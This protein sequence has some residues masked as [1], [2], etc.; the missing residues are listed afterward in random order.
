MPLV[1]LAPVPSAEESFKA[2]V[3]YGFPRPYPLG[4]NGI[5][6]LRGDGVNVMPTKL[7]RQSFDD[8]TKSRLRLPRTGLLKNLLWKFQPAELPAASPPPVYDSNQGMF[9]LGCGGDCGCKEC[10]E[11]HGVSGL[12]DW[13]PTEA[14]AKSGTSE[15]PLGQ[16]Y[17]QAQKTASTT[18]VGGGIQA[19]NQIFGTIFGAYQQTQQQKQQQ[20]QNKPKIVVQQQ[21]DWI[22]PAVIVGGVLVAGVLAVAVARGGKR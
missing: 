6:G 18:P 5:L 17:F 22:V 19:F 13:V 2:V 20:Q 16:Q 8:R 1:D 7:V 21:P 15:Y 3:N 9:G 12:R 14:E 10:K 4:I 11:Q